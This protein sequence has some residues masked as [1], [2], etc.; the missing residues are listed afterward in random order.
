MEK[1]SFAQIHMNLVFA[2][3]GGAGQG[4][5]NTPESRFAYK[6]ADEDFAVGRTRLKDLERQGIFPLLRKGFPNFGITQ[7]MCRIGALWTSCTIV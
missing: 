1:V 5:P 7:A 3:K 2:V 4:L 6:G